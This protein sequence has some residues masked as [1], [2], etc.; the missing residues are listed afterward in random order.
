MNLNNEIQILEIRV[1]DRIKK[2]FFRPF[3]ITNNQGPSC[4]QRLKVLTTENTTNM[5]PILDTIPFRQ[6]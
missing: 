1:S 6:C 2:L 5:N 3:N 4:L